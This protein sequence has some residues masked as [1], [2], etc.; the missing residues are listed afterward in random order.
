LQDKVLRNVLLV[1]IVFREVVLE[2]ELRVVGVTEEVALA[3]WFDFVVEEL[4]GVLVRE[5]DNIVLEGTDTFEELA[6]I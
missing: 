6:R 2:D 5:L 3:D 4:E 1:P